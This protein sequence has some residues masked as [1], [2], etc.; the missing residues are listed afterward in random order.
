MFKKTVYLAKLGL[1]FIVDT[2]VFIGNAE[3]IQKL[4]PAAEY[5]VFFFIASGLY[6]SADAHTA[7]A[8]KRNFT[9]FTHHKRS[10]A[11]RV[12]QLASLK[13]LGALR[14]L[15]K[16]SLGLYILLAH[17]ALGAE[18]LK[19]K[20]NG[21]GYFFRRSLY[22]QHFALF[23]RHC[24]GNAFKRKGSKAFFD[25]FCKLRNF[26]VKSR[27]HFSSLL[28]APSVPPLFLR[29]FISTVLFSSPRSRR[30]MFFLC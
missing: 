3:I 2:S 22:L 30:T 8:Q 27:H 24:K 12:V 7:A 13:A 5:I 10:A 19:L 6:R 11:A 18:I 26:I 17:S 15:F 29:P 14:C 21:I 16:D 25:G 9:F 23:L 1:L 4:F 28:S 20:D